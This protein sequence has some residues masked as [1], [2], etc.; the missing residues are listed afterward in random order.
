MKKIIGFLWKYKTSLGLL[1]SYL[2]GLMMV[3]KMALT[4]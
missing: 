3:A 1:L 4:P 2:I